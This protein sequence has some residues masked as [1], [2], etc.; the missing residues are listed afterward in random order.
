M[1]KEVLRGID[2]GK[3]LAE[4]A[5]ELNM[6][7]SALLGMVEHLEKMGY[8]HSSERSGDML[9]MCKTCAL[10]RVCSKHGPKIYYLTEK[11]KRAIK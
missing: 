1:I 8:L 5:E 7:Y 10:Y 9:L 4:I 2:S 11:G 3:T 6:E